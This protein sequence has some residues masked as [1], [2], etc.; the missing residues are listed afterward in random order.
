[1]KIVV[2]GGAGFIGS[3]VVDAHLAAGH[4]VVVVDDLSTGKRENLNPRARF[5]EAS[6][7]DGT[8]AA[9]IRRERPDV[10]NHHAAQIS[11][12]RSVD[13]PALDA[14]VNVLG[15]I[16]LLEAARA[17]GVKRFVFVS[18]GGAVYGE[19]EVYPA[20][21]THTTWPVSPCQ[22]SNAIVAATR[23]TEIPPARR[24]TTS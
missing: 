10:V 16:A 1:M 12:R 4:E 20:P 5:V 23:R 22:P 13:D 8:T 2:T 7:L 17:A 3:H 18:S 14:R 6:I 11:V 19:Q 9:L 15:T 24:T 21:E